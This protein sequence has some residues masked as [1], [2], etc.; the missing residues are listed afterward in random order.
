MLE[1]KKVLLVMGAFA[2]LCDVIE[3][4]KSKGIHVIVTD[5][6][7]D[8]PG[9]KIADEHY[10]VSI[11]D[12]DQLVALCKERKVDGIMNYCIDPG[13]KPYQQVCALLGYPSYGT[14]E[15]FEVMTNKDRFKCQCVK[16]G[17]GVIPA[18]RLD[19]N[20]TSSDISRLEF[21]LIVK[22]VDGRASKGNTVCLSEAD[23]PAAIETALSHSGRKKFL[24]EEYLSGLQEVVVKYFVCDGQVA[25]TSMADLYTHFTDD[26]RRAYI[27]FQVFPSRFYLEY[28][29]STDSK[30]REMIKDL[31]IKN[32]PLSFDGFV[33]RGTFRFFDPSFRMGGAQDWR[34]VE[35]I[36][37]VNIADFLTHFAI[38]GRMGDCARLKEIDGAF[39]NKSAAMVYFLARKGRIGKV[40]GLDQLDEHLDVIGFHLSHKEGD[41]I[42]HF[43][44][45]DMVILRVL[46]VSDNLEK[47]KAA[48]L[49]V[50]K[51]ID[52]KDCYG[53]SMLLP[54]FDVSN[55]VA[56]V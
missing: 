17:I 32:G 14:Q 34:I 13:Q 2:Q 19:H 23:L 36:T 5:Y 38:H 35:S 16:H 27:N 49:A 45:S 26:G 48:V 7:V 20:L 30:V 50:Q 53:D 15:Q 6:L 46:V 41:T 18:F 37:G 44:T 24:V 42:E 12:V 4:A 56:D 28:L 52:V 10:L 47:L 21:P 51:T 39:A 54:G 29:K 55:L 9:K 1:G 31:Q 8:S 40:S 3:S 25:L 43:G 22:P 11:T 33:D